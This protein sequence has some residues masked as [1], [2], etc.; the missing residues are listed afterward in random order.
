M[1]LWTPQQGSVDLG[2][3]AAVDVNFAGTVVGSRVVGG[4]RRAF[5]LSKG[6]RAGDLLTTPDLDHDGLPETL[7]VTTRRDG[8]I[9]MQRHNAAGPAAT[10]N[11]RF[12]LN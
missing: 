11:Y 12:T 9:I 10:K 4:Q 7:V 5:V 8:R 3:G 6:L 1:F 2:D